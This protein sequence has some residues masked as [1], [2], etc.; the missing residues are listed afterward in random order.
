MSSINNTRSINDIVADVLGQAVALVRDELK[1][2]RAEVEEKATRARSALVLLVIGAVVLLDAT[3]VI[4]GAIVFAIAA[5]GL[6]LA[7]SAA[8][9]GVVALVVGTILVMQGIAGL[10]PEKFKLEKT[11]EQLRRDMALVRREAH[12]T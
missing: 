10:K 9:V 11:T 6:S 7:V 3:L 8:I 4:L 12:S 2:A 5:H 1:L